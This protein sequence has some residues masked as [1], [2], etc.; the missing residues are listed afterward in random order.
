MQD[1][2]TVVPFKALKNETALYDFFMNLIEPDLM[3]AN[4]PVLD[5]AYAGETAEERSE[6]YAH[7]KAAFATCEEV[8]QAL[9]DGSKDFAKTLARKMDAVANTEDSDE[10]SELLKKITQDISDQ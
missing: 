8:I 10:R 9:F 2:P 3:T 1:I 5:D 6:R 7:Y 4:L